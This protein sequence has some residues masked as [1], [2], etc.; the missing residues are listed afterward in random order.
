MRTFA[1]A[2]LATAAPLAAQT[3]LEPPVKLADFVVTP[4]RFGVADVP[5]TT[6]ASLT[7]AEIEV[8]P[9]LGDDLFRSI[10]RLPGLAADDVSAQFWVRGAPQSQLLAR[11]DGVDLIEPFHLKDVDGALSIVDPA[12][13]RRLDLST[14]GF[15]AEYGDRLAGVLTMETKTAARPRTALGLSLTGVGGNHHGVFAGNR[16]RWLVSARR[17]YPDIALKASGRRDDVSPRY[18]D[19]FGKVEYD[20]GPAHTLSFHVLHAGDAL[21]YERRN[22]PSLTSSYD[23]DYAW[24][25]WQGSFGE[26][27]TGEAVLSYAW[28]TWK[29]DGSGR[30]DGFPFA[31]H[32]RRNLEQVALRND[33][34]F[35]VND[36]LVLRGGVEG[37][38]ATANYNYV[39][40]RRYNIVEGGRQLPMDDNRV[41]RRRPEGESAGG[42]IAARM[43]PIAALVFEPGVRFDRHDWAHPFLFTPLVPTF[44]GYDPPSSPHISANTEPNPR[45]NAALMVGLATIR[46]AW[47][48]YAQTEGLQALETSK[49][50]DFNWPEWAEHRVFGIEY[51]LA[52]T[53]T[54][55]VEAYERI[56]TNVASRW[57]NVDN[58]YDLFPELQD[59][60]VLIRPERGRTRGVEVL[61]S[62][63][64]TGPLTWHASY[65]I[66]RA[67]ERI[68]EFAG[69][70][71]V[72]RWVPRSHDQRHAFHA[73]VTYVM[74]PRWQFSAAW[75]YHTGW[76]TTDVVYSLTTLANGRRALVSNNGPVYGLRL[77]DYHRLDLRATRRITLRRG[78]LRL[79]LDVFNAYDRVN[80]LGYDHR[81]TIS[82]TQVTNEKNPRE[83][84]PLLPSIGAEWEF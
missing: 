21:R 26:R 44:F 58:P 77:P 65:A 41:L 29:R 78:E 8:L 18:Y 51:P 12:I 67:E 9:Q 32:D 66:S 37:K 20:V 68:A 42:F 13:I 14:G 27:L 49:H 69:Q 6:A 3:A 19:V 56:H 2:C 28:L 34:S 55:R 47:G 16:G 54:L 4:S 50:D 36:R 17:G 73:D 7:A 30:M 48:R 57:E 10:A 31:L 62:S 71:L 5:T 74:N 72:S 59:D 76:P 61:L 39:L 64:G 79:F 11:L 60:R 15:T 52:R 25:R 83:Q 70:A 38:T 84:L 24:G 33:W 1:L 45:L 82:G 40:S 35:S 63:L 81:V 22:N 43:Q 46:A 23:S 53:A 75:Q 80:L